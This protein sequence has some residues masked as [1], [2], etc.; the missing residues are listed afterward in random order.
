MP[1]LCSAHVQHCSPTGPV[2]GENEVP[3]NLVALSQCWKSSGDADLAASWD[4]LHFL[5][6]ERWLDGMNVTIA[7][8]DGDG[9]R[10][11]S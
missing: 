9:R 4:V 6:A 7:G 11:P 1:S 10:S 5:P 2:P 3:A 8:A